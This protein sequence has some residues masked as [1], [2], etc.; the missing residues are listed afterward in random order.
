MHDLLPAAIGFPRELGRYE[1]RSSYLYSHFKGLA[2]IAYYSRQFLSR[3]LNI[4]DGEMEPR[5]EV[6]R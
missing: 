5:Q 4:R 6:E 3:S 2:R 1:M